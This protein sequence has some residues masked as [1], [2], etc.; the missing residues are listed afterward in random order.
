[1]QGFKES[2]WY[3]IRDVSQAVSDLGAGICRSNEML[4]HAL[5]TPFA[6]QT[7]FFLWG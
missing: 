6:A 5:I 3:G 1:M 7:S 2:L 4:L